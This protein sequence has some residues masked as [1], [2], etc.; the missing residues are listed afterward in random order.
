MMRNYAIISIPHRDGWASEQ[1]LTKKAEGVAKKKK[2]FRG[3]TQ[4]MDNTVAMWQPQ[5]YRR[6]V[7][8]GEVLFR[9]GCATPSLAGLVDVDKENF[10]RVQPYSPAT[11]LRQ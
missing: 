7:G 3:T 1:A 2:S 9:Q 8:G 5:Q 4:F 11:S 6:H 10:F